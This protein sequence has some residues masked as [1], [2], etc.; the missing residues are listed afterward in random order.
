MVVY[1]YCLFVYDM[2][3]L[4]KLKPLDLCKRVDCDAV[5]VH[6]SSPMTLRRTKKVINRRLV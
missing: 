1:T 3:D 2:Y 6:W 4:E 5:R